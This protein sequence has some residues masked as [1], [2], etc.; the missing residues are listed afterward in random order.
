[1]YQCGYYNGEDLVTV[2][3]W[4][5]FKQET[6]VTIEPGKVAIFLRNW[7]L[8]IDES[9]ETGVRLWTAANPSTSN[10]QVTVSASED[11]PAYG[12]LFTDNGLNFD[13]CVAF[14]DRDDSIIFIDGGC[15]GSVN[16]TTHEDWKFFS[17]DY[18][19]F[20]PLFLK[21]AQAQ[22]NNP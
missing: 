11:D 4:T 19:D 6:T 22:E 20:R 10:K 7:D 18:I 17:I 8:T 13:K 5:M 12:F 21:I 16:G 15:G 2:D 1:M 9:E 3:T 14:L